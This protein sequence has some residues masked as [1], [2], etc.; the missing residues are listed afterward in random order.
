M[1]FYCYLKFDSFPDFSQFPSVAFCTSLGGFLK[2]HG[3]WIGVHTSSNNQGTTRSQ[4]ITLRSLKILYFLNFNIQILWITITNNYLRLS[5]ILSEWILRLDCFE[6]CDHAEISYHFQI[7][8][9]YNRYYITR[10]HY[11]S[12]GTKQPPYMKHISMVTK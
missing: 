12:E 4:R 2:C 9:S 11:Q 6:F 1:V 8:S 10:I 3:L 5:L 7:S